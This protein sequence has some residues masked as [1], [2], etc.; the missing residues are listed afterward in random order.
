MLRF[1]VHPYNLYYKDGTPA[2]MSYTYC[3]DDNQ[4]P[5]DLSEYKKA[6]EEEFES[7]THDAEGAK[8]ILEKNASKAALEVVSLALQSASDHLRFKA[9]SYILDNTV[10]AREG[11]SDALREFVD[12]L[13]K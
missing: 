10:F 5:L 3:M 2:H 13:K 6:L 7:D 9:A 1:A 12:S 4:E 11:D 8:R